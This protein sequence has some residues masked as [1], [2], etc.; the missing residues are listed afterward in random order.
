M[1]NERFYSANTLQSSHQERRITVE[2]EQKNILH[3]WRKWG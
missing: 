1:N 2:H 3:G